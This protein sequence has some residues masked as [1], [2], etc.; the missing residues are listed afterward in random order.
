M[1]VDGSNCV[2]GAAF[3]CAKSKLDSALLSSTKGGAN[4]YYYCCPQL[5]G[6]GL[7]NARPII[8]HRMF[9]IFHSFLYQSQEID[10]LNIFPNAETAIPEFTTKM[11]NC[12][13]A[14]LNPRDIVYSTKE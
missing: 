9:S 7:V 10:K 11:N 14:D 3:I 12:V 13:T 5:G 8:D 6:W 4:L 2:L 1:I